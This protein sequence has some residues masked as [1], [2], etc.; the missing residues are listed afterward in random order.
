MGLPI[1]I[2][3]KKI[4]FREQSKEFQTGNSLFGQ[5]PSVCETAKTGEQQDRD[6][7]LF[8]A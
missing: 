7:L 1:G 5:L 6:Y 2:S 3:L 8:T 4:F